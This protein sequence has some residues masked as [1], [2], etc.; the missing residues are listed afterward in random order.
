ML[1]REETEALLGEL[2]PLTYRESALLYADPQYVMPAEP[3][4][5]AVRNLCDPPMTE[6]EF[7]ALA[8]RLEAG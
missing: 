4:I 7:D 1:T 2:I 3:V 5:T 8:D 6:D